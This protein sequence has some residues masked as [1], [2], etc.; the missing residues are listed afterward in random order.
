MLSITEVATNFTSLVH[1]MVTAPSRTLG[2]VQWQIPM[3]S[4]H[5]S[6]GSL[7][8]DRIVRLYLIPASKTY[9]RKVTEAVLSLFNMPGETGDANSI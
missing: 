9:G 7:V 1:G 3:P 2:Q 8:Q 6:S 4:E 5:T